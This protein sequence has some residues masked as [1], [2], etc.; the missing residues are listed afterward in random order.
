[1]TKIAE[2]ET[3]FKEVSCFFPL[4]QFPAEKEGKNVLLLV[5]T[6]LKKK[7]IHHLYISFDFVFVLYKKCSQYFRMMPNCAKKNYSNYLGIE[8]SKYL[9]IYVVIVV[10]CLFSRITYIS[11]EILCWKSRD[12]FSFFLY[13][14]LQNDEKMRPTCD[15]RKSDKMPYINGSD[16]DSQSRLEWILEPSFPH[17]TIIMSSTLLVVI[18]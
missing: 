9:P 18:Q 3:E 15:Q 17:T 1:M 16:S 11:I 12:C 10:Y 5:G 6:P 8:E 7:K 13:A 2:N 4:H 14:K